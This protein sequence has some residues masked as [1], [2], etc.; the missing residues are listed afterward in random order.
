MTAMDAR[1]AAAHGLHGI[2]LSNHGGRNLDT[3]PTS[4]LLLLELQRNCPE[5]FS[6]LEVLVDGGVRR[7]TDVFKALCLGARA[8]GIGRGFMYALNYGQEGVEKFI[9]SKSL[10]LHCLFS[11]SFLLSSSLAKILRID[12]S[13]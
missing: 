10:L 8:V 6:K 7:G 11:F 12:L 13:C 9:E 3:T 5:V 2:V 1:L 4:I